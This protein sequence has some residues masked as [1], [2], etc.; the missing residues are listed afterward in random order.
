M[1]T[2]VLTCAMCELLTRFPNLELCSDHFLRQFQSVKIVCR[3]TKERL[4]GLKNFDSVS[5]LQQTLLSIFQLYN[6]RFWITI[7][8][9]VGS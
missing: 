5:N 4:V 6:C 3:D 7:G 2:L 8:L 9:G 1:K